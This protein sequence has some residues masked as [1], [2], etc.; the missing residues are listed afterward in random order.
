M[1]LLIMKT[2]ITF[3]L[4]FFFLQSFKSQNGICLTQAQN[5]NASLVSTPALDKGDFNNDGKEDICV[6]G[7]DTSLYGISVIKLYSSSGSGSFTA[8][9]HTLNFANKLNARRIDF[10]KTGD[11]NSDGK[12]DV[13]ALCHSDSIFYL[14]GTGNGSLNAAVSFSLP[15]EPTALLINDFNSDGKNDLVVTS[16]VTPSVS[17]LFG[18]GTGGF[19]S[20]NHYSLALPATQLVSGDF[21]NNGTL[22]IYLITGGN[23]YFMKGSGTGGFTITPTFS[24]D[25]GSLK[26]EDINSDNKLDLVYSDLTSS[27]LCVRM[28]NGNFTFSSVTTYSVNKIKGGSSITAVGP[29]EIADFNKDGNKD[30]AV[31]SDDMNISVFLGAANGVFSNSATYTLNS[32]GFYLIVFN[33]IAADIS[34]DGKQDIVVLAGDM[35]QTYLGELKVF[36]NCNTVGINKEYYIAGKI[37]LFP[38]PAKD[39][40]QIETSEN[41]FNRIFIYNELGQLL[42]EEE[43]E[44][45]T[46]NISELSNGV[47]SLV[48]KDKNSLTVS[49]CF[50]IAR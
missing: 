20:I 2:Q 42:R 3:L 45:N 33:L 8:S 29:V 12:P 40:L 36:L 28:G 43:L 15:Y 6:S 18:N 35:G 32:T 26:V 23:S 19:S 16:N 9:T 27:K 34:G 46:L 37:K 7:S 13:F 48:L 1:K 41:T 47:Y 30:I 11:F 5:P 25:C 24:L 10:L 17:I 31:L 39:Y 14:N 50:I 22:D 21:N 49:K 38:N 44:N 4:V